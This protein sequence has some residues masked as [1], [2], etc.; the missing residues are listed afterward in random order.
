MSPLPTTTEDQLAEKQNEY[1]RLAKWFD[2][3][4]PRSEDFS[5][6]NARIAELGSPVLELGCGTG[7]LTC[8]LA[9]DGGKIIGL[10]LSSKQL[11][12]AERRRSQM[13]PDIA[14]NVEFRQGTMTRF[15]FPERFRLIIIPFSALLELQTAQ[16]RL[17]TFRRCLTHLAD[18]GK[19]IF[20]NFY[21]GSGE[22][23]NWGK[24]RPANVVTF[25]G[26]HPHPDES[27]AQIH[28]FEV[29][30]YESDGRMLLTIFID[31][32]SNTGAVNRQTIQVKR[33]Y[34]SP[35]DSVQELRSAGFQNVRVYGSFAGHEIGDPAVAGRGRIVCEASR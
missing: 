33:Q 8:G 17:N 16:E 32:V 29:Q 35:E 11:E 24:P 12:R 21:R 23:V 9:T 26:I 3:L 20:D 30:E 4:Y 7:R 15:S 1:D 6:Y 5:Y 31:Q 10:D 28:H 13:S 25:W 18:G 27:D 19:L 22:L 34:V 2:T 14:S